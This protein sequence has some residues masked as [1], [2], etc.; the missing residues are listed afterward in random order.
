MAALSRILVLMVV[1]D[2]WRNTD[3]WKRIWRSVNRSDELRIVRNIDSATV[4]VAET[5]P[6]VIERENVGADVGVYQDAICG[7]LPLPEWDWLL[8]APDDFLPMRVDFVDVF[9][10]YISGP[11]VGLIVS[12]TNEGVDVGIPFHSRSAAFMIR[13]DIAKRL[14][15]PCDPVASIADCRAFEFGSHNFLRQVQDMGVAVQYTSDADS[16]VFWDQEHEHYRHRFPEFP[17]RDICDIMHYSGTDK[18]AVYSY[19]DAYGPL[20]EPFRNTRFP[21]LEIGVHA[22]NS[23]RAWRDFFPNAHIH[24][25][26]INPSFMVRGEDRISTHLMDAR[27]VRSLTQWAKDNGP[28][29]LIVDDGSHV[30]ED[31]VL[32]FAVL[33]HLLVDDGLYVIEGVQSDGDME[34]LSHLPGAIVLDRRNIKGRSDD[35]MVVFRRLIQRDHSATK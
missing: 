26:D 29:Q 21:I 7:R 27:D 22:G 10:S 30:L 35:I 6:L 25:I 23:L 2:R 14:T 32:A 24:G 8:C 11:D 1:Y 9:R 15:F 3:R 18:S 28:F 31:M 34:A 20:I 13:R 4:R 17:A 19:C 12:K 16:D 5:E 33:A